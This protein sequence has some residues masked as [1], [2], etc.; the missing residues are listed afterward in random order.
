[1]FWS[2]YH[3]NYK[4]M[5]HAR[6]FETWRSQVNNKTYKLSYNKAYERFYVAIIILTSIVNAKSIKLL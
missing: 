5:T 1:M 2:Y 6:L 4:C 3:H